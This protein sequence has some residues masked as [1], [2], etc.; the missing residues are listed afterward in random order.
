MT[1]EFSCLGSYIF[2]SI[3]EISACSSC[4]QPNQI[5]FKVN[6]IPL[7]SRMYRAGKNIVSTLIKTKGRMINIIKPY[8]TPIKKLISQGNKH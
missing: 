2:K 8:L 7:P 1:S 6:I 5:Y 4:L 3:L